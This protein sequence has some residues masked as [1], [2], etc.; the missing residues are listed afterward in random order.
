MA[1]GCTKPNIFVIRRALSYGF[2]SSVDEII[3]EWR[4]SLSLASYYGNP[5]AVEYLLQ[6]HA[7]VN[8]EGA[9][10]LTPLA[11]AL[12]GL[13]GGVFADRNLTR[14]VE[15]ILRLLKAGAEPKCQL[16]ASLLGETGLGTAVTAVIDA[17][18]DGKL[19]PAYA[20]RLVENLVR[21]GA[22]PNGMGRSK[23][24]PLRWA[25]RHYG[26]SGQLFHYLLN[27][28]ADPDFP[29]HSGT[30]C[31]ALAEAIRQDNVTAMEHLISHGAII[32][33][34]TYQ[35]FPL[36]CAIARQKLASLAALLRHAADP[37]AV[38]MTRR[39]QPGGAVHYRMTCVSFAVWKTHFTEMGR[40]I[41]E[42]L[43]RFG[44]DPNIRDVRGS[45]TLYY[46]LILPSARSLE[47]TDLLLNR[48][49][50]PNE[51]TYSTNGTPLVVATRA[52]A[53]RPIWLKEDDARKFTE[54]ATASNR[55]AVVKRLLDAGAD[56]NQ[57]SNV[58]GRL[59]SP[60]EAALTT[61][62]F[63]TDQESTC[64]TGASMDYFMLHMLW[65]SGPQNPA[66][67]R[68]SPSLYRASQ[69]FRR[70]TIWFPSC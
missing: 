64:V 6:Q 17:A 44:A 18:V 26:V 66:F 41:L 63:P 35:G 42:H 45:P 4:S 62:Y 56:V 53:F 31:T 10:G 60:L 9:D 14:H 55:V 25:I 21:K 22:S 20:Q 65:L 43:L 54:Q 48:G 70:R 1:Y 19:I 68:S 50:D 69:I 40:R 7:S 49:A 38:D 27:H 61:P 15:S 33:P 47:I 5:S 2:P 67:R 34:T 39:P 28:G 3:F 29:G 30:P 23:V 46:A 58:Q 16:P 12:T 59:T 8:K 24:S 32:N 51:Q 52:H 36:A 37:N 11:H 13:G 57:P